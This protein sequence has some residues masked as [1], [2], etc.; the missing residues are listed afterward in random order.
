M[1]KGKDNWKTEYEKGL[2]KER[3][4]R[5]RYEQEHNRYNPEDNKRSQVSG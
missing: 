3:L 5:L 4:A 2:E 1:K